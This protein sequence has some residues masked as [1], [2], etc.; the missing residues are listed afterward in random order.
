MDR[1]RQTTLRL[2]AVLFG[3][4]ALAGCAAAHGQ[5]LKTAPAPLRGARLSNLD[6]SA[7]VVWGIDRNGFLWITADSGRTWRVPLRQHGMGKRVT[8]KRP[9]RLVFHIDQV[10]FVDKRHG[11]ITVV[12][13]AERHLGPGAWPVGP[14]PW[15]I[16]RTVDG[17]RTWQVSWPPG[18]GCDGGQVSF[19]DARHG[20]VLAEKNG[21][22]SLVFRTDDGGASW[23]RVARTSVSGLIAFVDR[24]NGFLTTPAGTGNAPPGSPPGTRSFIPPVL[25]RTSDGGKNWSKYRVPR[26]HGYANGVSSLDHRLIGSVGKRIYES[27]DGGTHWSAVV[28]PGRP[29]NL[30]PSLS[31]G[32]P[33]TVVYYTAGGLYVTH[34][35]GRSWETI[36]PRGLPDEPTG[37]VFSS[38]R[39]AWTFEWRPQRPTIYRSTDAGRHWKRYLLRPT[40]R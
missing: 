20:Y 26:S 6:A 9:N 40:K 30:H 13:Q 14:H 7:G 32:L 27:V 3:A 21:A 29:A 22:H 1:L 34:N 35:D 28:P 24:R 2:G 38:P 8:S 4:I 39:V 12:P 10:Q 36:V 23:R 31:T 37:I 11:W 16:E 15:A 17:G 19:Y 25:Y 5:A 33:G 18:C